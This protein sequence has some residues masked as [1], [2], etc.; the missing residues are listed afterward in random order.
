MASPKTTTVPVTL[1][2]EILVKQLEALRLLCSQ[3]G[4][5]LDA[6]I[7]ALLE[8]AQRNGEADA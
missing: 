7:L 5:A 4:F 1:D 8:T 6:A 2:G 3:I